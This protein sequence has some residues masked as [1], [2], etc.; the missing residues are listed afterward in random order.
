MYHGSKSSVRERLPSCQQPIMSETYRNAIIVEASSIL[1]KRL[2]VS[3]DNFYEFAVVFYHYVIP[4][5][6][7]FNWLDVVFDRYFKNSL[8]AQARKGQ[9]SSGTRVLQ[10]TDDVPFS[11]NFLTSFLCNKD[12]KH[13]LGLLYLASGIV[14]IQSDVGN[15][16]LLLFSTHDNSVIFFPPTVNDTVFQI[17]SATQG[18]DQKI[19]G[20]ALHCIKFGYYFIEVQSIVTD[21]LILLLAYIA[22]ELVSNND[23]FNLYLKLV[24]PNPTWYNILSLIEHLT[25]DV[26]KALPH[27]Y[28]FTGC[29]IVSNVNGKRKFIFFDTWMKRKKKNDLTKRFIKLGNIAESI[30][31]GDK[32][33]LEF[34]VKTV[35][36]GNVKDIRNISLNEMRKHQFTQSTLNDL[37]KIAPSS[38]VLKMHSLRAAHTAAFEWVQDLHNVSVPNLSVGGYVLKDN[39]FVPKWLS[40]VSTFNVAEFL[41]TC[42]CKTAKCVTCKCAKLGISCLPQCLC[43]RERIN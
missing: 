10:I 2:E 42:K 37:M 5:V 24:I 21:I 25:I 30:N 17:S 4:L 1:R 3:A 16:H 22:M 43:K 33:K 29:D 18:A 15:T 12:N 11:R 7:G 41:Q 13:D 36:F 26:C 34:L 23:L 31:S 9:G 8:K 28:A 14:F 19:I 38:D 40:K 6:E 20:H 39:I 27:F 35:Y 32:N